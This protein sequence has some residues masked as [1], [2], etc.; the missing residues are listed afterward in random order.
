MSVVRN[1][2]NPSK[3][4]APRS[5]HPNCTHDLFRNP[6]TGSTALYNSVQQDEALHRRERCL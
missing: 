4:L 5:N 6:K 3:P 2:P 1:P